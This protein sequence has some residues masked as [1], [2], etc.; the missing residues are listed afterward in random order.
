MI[1]RMQ[2]IPCGLILFLG[3]DGRPVYGQSVRI[4]FTYMF[5]G[6]IITIM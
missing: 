5:D 6:L 4:A 1:A 3:N 2:V